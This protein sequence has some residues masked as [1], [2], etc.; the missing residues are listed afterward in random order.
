[1]EAVG[2]AT[3]ATTAAVENFAGAASRTVFGDRWHEMLFGNPAGEAQPGG[4]ANR[5]LVLPPGSAAA[6]EAS[7][8]AKFGMEAA[9]RAVAEE[10]ARALQESF[11]TKAREEAEAEERRKMIARTNE[12]L[13][14]HQ[15]IQGWLRSQGS[16]A[17]MN[18]RDQREAEQAYNALVSPLDRN[19]RPKSGLD[20]RLRENFLAEGQ[21]V[22]AG[23]VRDALDALKSRLKEGAVQAFNLRETLKQQGLNV[24]GKGFNVIEAAGA[25]AREAREKRERAGFR[26]EILGNSALSDRLQTTA[27]SQTDK[28]EEKEMIRQLAAANQELKTG[29]GDLKRT[30]GDLRGLG[31]LR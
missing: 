28:R 21:K 3:A 25:P 4:G 24:V 12:G 18:A 9:R 2:K 8:G 19:G 20:A 31:A 30:I 13:H 27:L 11:L 23:P 26:S 14:K 29:F 17:A 5:G 10:R 6:A 7:G 16:E 15:A 1:M 22:D